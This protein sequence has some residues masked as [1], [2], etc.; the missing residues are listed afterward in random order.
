VFPLVD[1]VLPPVP[2][3]VRDHHRAV[4]ASDPCRRRT[5]GGS[6]GTDAPF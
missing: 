3:D 2:G 4:D 1:V 6:S 5:L